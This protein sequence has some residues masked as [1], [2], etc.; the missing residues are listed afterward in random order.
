MKPE[1]S[2]VEQI[3]YGV[4]DVFFRTRWGPDRFD[5]SVVFVGAL[6]RL[7]GADLLLDM[8][9]RFPKR[10]WRMVFVGD[11]PLADELRALND[12]KVEVLGRV[13][14]EKV[15][16]ALRTSWLLVHP[17]RADTSPNAVKEARVMGLPVIGSPN[18]GHAEYIDSGRDGLIV[19]SEDADDWFAAI[20]QM[21]GDFEGCCSMGR[22][23]HQ[24]FR[25]HFRPELTAKAFSELYR[26][27]VPLAASGG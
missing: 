9:R 22:R 7:K 6:T 3:E 23:R 11:A 21:C 16:K 25:E 15:A 5:P 17:S 14:R 24:W 13:N 2:R 8:L 26:R 19:D 27:M 1:P 20:E 18:G 10:S 12:A 4:D